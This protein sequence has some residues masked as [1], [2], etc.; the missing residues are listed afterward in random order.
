MT[1]NHIRRKIDFMSTIIKQKI[2]SVC[3]Q[4][5]H[6]YY[7]HIPMK[8]GITAFLHLKL[9]NILRT[10]CMAIFTWRTI[11]W[12]YC[13]KRSGKLKYIF[14]LWQMLKN[15][16]KLRKYNY[17]CIHIPLFF[18]YGSGLLHLHTIWKAS[19]SNILIGRNKAVPLLWPF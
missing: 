11:I 12:R 9:Y 8:T 6:L 4:L 13:F 14:K 7:L 16:V 18:L 17:P 15:Y 1:I 10:S 19:Y 3:Y 2:T 5:H